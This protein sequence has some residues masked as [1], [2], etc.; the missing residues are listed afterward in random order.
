MTWLRKLFRGRTLPPAS[1]DPSSQPRFVFSEP[2]AIIS[3][4]HGNLQAL[5]AVL[6]DIEERGIK[7]R[8]C[9]G[10]IVGY[11]GNPAECVDLIRTSSFQCIRGNHDAYAA[12]TTP[13]PARSPDFESACRWMSEQLGTERCHWLGSLPFTL[14]AQDY[15]AVHTSLHRPEEWPYVL[16]DGDAAENF[17]HQRKPVCFAGHTHQPVLWIEGEQRKIEG[18]G[19]ESLRESR[20]HLV[21]V[22]AV[23]QPR[24]EDPHACYVIYRPDKREVWWRRV[25]YDIAGAQRAIIEAG[26][27]PK[28]AGRLDLGK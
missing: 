3:D 6:A 9:L 21:N 7:E 26:L 17:R 24:D 20:K 27:P 12:G 22:G 2:V 28:N 23:G 16:L 19:I 13:L 5:Q 1:A 25:A 10:D 15:E 11:G 8:V 4:V 18:G 14:S